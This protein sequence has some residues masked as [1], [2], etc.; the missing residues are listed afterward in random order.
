EAVPTP[1]AAE[2]PAPPAAPAPSRV[3]RVRRVKPEL[4]K[5]TEDLR[6]RAAIARVEADRL[7][8]GERAPDIFEEGERTER[9]GLRLLK[10]REYDAAQVAFSRAAQLF[11]EAREKTWEERVRDTSLTQRSD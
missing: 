8:A 7:H 3:A 10:D 4:R 6:Y 2:A 1:S 11:D 5:S 9:E